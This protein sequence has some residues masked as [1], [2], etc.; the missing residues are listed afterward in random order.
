MVLLHD[1]ST[2]AQS[3]GG[4]TYYRDPAARA[5]QYGGT[6]YTLSGWQAATGLASTDQAV[7]GVPTATRVFV[8]PN[9]YELGRATVVV[10]NW[11]GQGAV[12]V[13]LSGVLGVGQRYEVHNAQDFYGTPVASGTFGGGTLSVPLGG[14]TPPAVIGGSPTAPLKTGPAF[15]VFIVTPTP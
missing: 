14:V 2:A 9:T 1:A 5:W 12:S 10:Y 8:R 7:S 11:G 6:D 13:D 15:D 4:N 3:W